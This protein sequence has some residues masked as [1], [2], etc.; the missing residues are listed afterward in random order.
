MGC[1]FPAALM[2]TA[3]VLLD[4]VVLVTSR[5]ILTDSQLWFWGTASIYFC[6]RMWNHEDAAGRS[7]SLFGS[8]S[9]WFKVFLAGKEFSFFIYLVFVFLNASLSFL[10]LFFFNPS[11]FYDFCYFLFDL[12]DKVEQIV[13]S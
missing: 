4:G 7:I 6:L 9:W 8:A 12:E 1:S 2:A 3:F 13:F 5:L 11:I 10:S